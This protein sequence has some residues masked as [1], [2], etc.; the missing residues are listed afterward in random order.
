MFVINSLYNKSILLGLSEVTESRNDYMIVKNCILL[1]K[2]FQAKL[3][4][5]SIHVSRQLEKIGKLLDV[6]KNTVF[7]SCACN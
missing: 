6:I 2:C 1:S 3:W 7:Y 5:N 4:E